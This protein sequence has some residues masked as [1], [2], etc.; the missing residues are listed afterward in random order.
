MALVYASLVN[1]A[2]RVSNATFTASASAMHLF[3]AP[4]S[5]HTWV[6]LPTPQAFC[7]CAAFLLCWREK[8]LSKS[9]CS[10]QHGGDPQG[11]VEPALKMHLRKTTSHIV[12]YIQR[13]HGLVLGALVVEY[14]RN[15]DGKWDGHEQGHG[16]GARAQRMRMTRMM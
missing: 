11:V 7:V 8:S 12:N 5:L 2:L 6:V 13:A 3:W 9:S 1:T 4:L 15:L 14:V 16:I 10:E